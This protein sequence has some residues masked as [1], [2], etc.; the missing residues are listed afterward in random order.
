MLETKC[1]CLHHIGKRFGVMGAS[2]HEEQQ[3][4]RVRKGVRQPA[5]AAARAG[6]SSGCSTKVTNHQSA[7]TSSKD[8]PEEMSSS[9]ETLTTLSS[10]YNRII[11]RTLKVSTSS[12]MTIRLYRK[13][14]LLLT[15]VLLLHLLILPPLASSNAS[16][17]PPSAQI[18]EGEYL[19]CQGLTEDR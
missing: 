19:F 8:R 3:D 1:L 12:L 13:N 6:L 5:A 11:N 7:I 14:C 4:L 10:F 15:S 9:Q 18:I 17:T 16:N 2:D